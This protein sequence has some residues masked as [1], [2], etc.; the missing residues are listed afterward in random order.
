MSGWASRFLPPVCPS[1]ASSTSPMYWADRPHPSFLVSRANRLCDPLHGVVVYVSGGERRHRAL[2]DIPAPSFARC[3]PR[4]RQ[5]DG[6]REDRRNPTFL[7][8]KITCR[9]GKSAGA[10]PLI[11]HPPPTPQDRLPAQMLRTTPES[12][13]SSISPFS[14]SSEKRTQLA[15][16]SSH[17]ELGAYLSCNPRHTIRAE[18]NG[19]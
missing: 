12:L 13:K 11:S 16:P 10:I 17:L 7:S 4:R 9:P 14:F 15:L 1:K 3:S 6:T 8:G 5:R 19:N 18:G 2:Q